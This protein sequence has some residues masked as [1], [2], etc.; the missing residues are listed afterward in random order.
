MTI[1]N[2]IEKGK[3]SEKSCKIYSRSH[4]STLESLLTEREEGENLARLTRV[5]PATQ[6]ANDSCERESIEQRAC[7]PN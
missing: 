7:A 6:S 5:D 2:C 1:I 3:S 4:L